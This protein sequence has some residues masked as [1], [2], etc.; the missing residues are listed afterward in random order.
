M[1]KRGVGPRGL[2]HAHQALGRE[3][4][5]RAGESGAR[6]TVVIETGGRYGRMVNVE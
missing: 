5:S 6:I 3:S 1:S 4:V 2:P